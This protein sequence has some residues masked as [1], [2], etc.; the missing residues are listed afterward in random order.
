LGVILAR[1]QNFPEALGLL[2]AYFDGRFRNSVEVE[3]VKQQI[4]A[5]EKLIAPE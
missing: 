5:L 1:K 2:R 3:T 4:A